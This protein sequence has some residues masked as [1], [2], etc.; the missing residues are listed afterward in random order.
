LTCYLDLFFLIYLVTNVVNRQSLAGSRDN[1]VRTSSFHVTRFP[2][3]FLPGALSKCRRPSLGIDSDYVAETVRILSHAI[4]NASVRGEDVFAANL[5]AW[6]TY[7]SCSQ[8]T[9]A[10]IH[11]KGGLAML[12]YL[13]DSSTLMPD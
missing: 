10:H 6:V 2:F 1:F 8:E 12:M 3:L 5:L 4:E 7:S 9:E 13:T 11:F